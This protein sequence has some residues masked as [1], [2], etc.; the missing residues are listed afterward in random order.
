MY[1]GTDRVERDLELFQG[2]EDAAPLLARQR[3]DLGG[4]QAAIAL[5]IGE[6]VSKCPADIDT[7]EIA[8]LVH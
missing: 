1:E 4:E 6:Q 8:C 2:L 7:D 5:V 3:P